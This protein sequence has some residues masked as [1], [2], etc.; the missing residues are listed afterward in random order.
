MDEKVSTD[1]ARRLKRAIE[2]ANARK[3]AAEANPANAGADTARRISEGIAEKAPAQSE[4]SWGEWFSS[5]AGEAANEVPQ[6]GDLSPLLKGEA[7]NPVTGL[8]NPAMNTAIGPAGAM[9]KLMN[10]ITGGLD[11]MRNSDK[12]TGDVNPLTSFATAATDTA[13]IGTLDRMSGVVDAAQQERTGLL[14]ELIKG[15]TGNIDEKA[16]SFAETAAAQRQARALDQEYVRS[17]NMAA[18]IAG[19]LA[20]SILSGSV[21]G[22]GFAQAAKATGGLLGSSGALGWASRTLLGATAAGTEAAAYRINKDGSLER[23]AGDAGLAFFGS[24]ALSSIFKGLGSATKAFTKPKLNDAMQESVGKEILTMMNIERQTQGL[25]VFKTLAEAQAAVAALGPDATIMDAFP[26]LRNMAADVIRNETDDMPAASLRELLAARNSFTE[27]LLAPDG[28]LRQAIGAQDVMGPRAYA[29]FA[30]EQLEALKP[31][32]TAALSPYKGTTFSAKQMVNDLG[33]LFGDRATMTQQQADLLEYA[34]SQIKEAQKRLP[35]GKKTAIPLEV[36]LDLKAQMQKLTGNKAITINGP[37]G[38]VIPLDRKA[39]RD[40]SIVED[41]FTG[42]S[43]TLAK[44]LIPLNKVYGS[45]AGMNQAYKLGAR[46]FGKDGVDAAQDFLGNVGK[47]VASKMAFVE[48]AKYALFQKLNAAT[49]ADDFARIVTENKPNL[50]RLSALIGEK[51]VQDMLAAVRPTI[52][53]VRT[54]QALSAAQNAGNL[55]MPETLM[56]SP[57][58]SAFDVLVGAGGATNQVSAA[59]GAG[60]VQ[61]LLRSVAKGSNPNSTARQKLVSDTL[62]AQGPQVSDY[63]GNLQVLLDK[64]FTPEKSKDFFGALKAGLLTNTLTNANEQ[65]DQQVPR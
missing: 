31:R 58:N 7:V 20:G 43:N 19:D 42:L 62:S 12:R 35:K 59:A 32:Y 51:S 61:R 29:N 26:T 15:F 65:A 57:L 46:V 18:S 41:Y 3:A 38:R 27:D 60:G 1:T 23:A 16:V 6:A 17:Q 9:G 2:E 48:G 37:S 14:P 30:N 56:N 44:D 53:K 25:P 4:Q 34:F 49:T 8:D 54:A 64:N 36:I 52:I 24:V 63:L 39:F 55:P 50:D 47:S 45:R 28:A 40:L 21:I 33:K 22:G 13:S 11:T 10:A 5:L